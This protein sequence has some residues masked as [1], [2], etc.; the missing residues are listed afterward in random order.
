MSLNTKYG[1][2]IEDMYIAEGIN[3]VYAYYHE[4]NED[5]KWYYSYIHAIEGSYLDGFNWVENYYKK[6][7]RRILR[8]WNYQYSVDKNAFILTEGYDLGP[9]FGFAELSDL[10]L[11]IKDNSAVISFIIGNTNDCMT[12]TISAINSTKIN[13]PEKATERLNNSI[14]LKNYRL[15]HRE[16]T[17][18]TSVL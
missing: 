11:V 2:E 3:G 12:I 5:S 10:T 17:S 8:D 4:I 6:D 13:L 9:L 16:V 18:S 15:V 7:L 14:E 1:T